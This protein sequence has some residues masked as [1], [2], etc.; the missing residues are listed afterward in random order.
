[1]VPATIASGTVRLQ[2]AQGYNNAVYLLNEACSKLYGNEEKGIKAR[3]IKEEDFVKAGG[4]KW[5]EARAAYTINGVTYGKQ[6][7]SAYTGNNKSYPTIYKKENN[8]VIDG[9]KK[10]D[11][12]SQSEQNALIGRTDES[13]TS[14]YL[15]ADTSIQP[16]QTYYYT[17]NYTKTAELLGDYAG[18]LLQNKSSTNYWVASRCVGLDSSGCDFYV[19]D[20]NSGCLIRSYVFYS[21]GNTFDN[22]RA[23]CP[24][25]SLSSQLLEKAENGTYNVK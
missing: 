5:T 9:S 23:V 13:A 21:D 4:T 20:V 25:V 11:G 15:A 6:F 14:G 19:R 17:G 2:G 8:S 16:Y 7:T 12:Y 1:M 24:V 10:T 3:S 22:S 18:I